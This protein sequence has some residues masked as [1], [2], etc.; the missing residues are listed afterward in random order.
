MAVAGFLTVSLRP[1]I[2]EA[3][4][5]LREALSRGGK[6]LFFGNGG[7]AAG[8]LNLGLVAASRDDKK[9]AAE[10]EARARGEM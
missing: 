1:R 2:L 9:H 3:A 8:C 10:L 5:T 7:S 4:R 6:V